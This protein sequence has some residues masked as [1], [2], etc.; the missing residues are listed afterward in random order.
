ME[1]IFIFQIKAASEHDRAAEKCMIYSPHK[2]LERINLDFSV[3]ASLLFSLSINV[4]ISL[5]LYL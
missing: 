1:F 5:P 4:S 2:G 3:Q